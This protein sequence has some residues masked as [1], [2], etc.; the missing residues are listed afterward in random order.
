MAVFISIW[1]LNVKS[2]PYESESE[3]FLKSE[4]ILAILKNQ[5]LVII[6]VIL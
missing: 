5:E 4:K 3:Y 1:T 2:S 6:I